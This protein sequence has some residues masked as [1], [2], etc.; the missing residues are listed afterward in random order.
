MA[1]F[2][3]GDGSHHSSRHG[4]NECLTEHHQVPVDRNRGI[5]PRGVDSLPDKFQRDKHCCPPRVFLSQPPD[6][7]KPRDLW[8]SGAFWPSAD[9]AI[10]FVKITPCATRS[11]AR[12]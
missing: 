6:K 11:L 3:V 9:S 12:C 7:M 10:N 2:V 4:F 1:I 5:L 8:V